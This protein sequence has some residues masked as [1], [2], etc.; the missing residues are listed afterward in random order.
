MSCAALTLTLA[1]TNELQKLLAEGQV[2]IGQ[3]DK[4]F[5]AEKAE[6]TGTNGIME[7]TGNPAWRAGPRGGKGDVL[8]VKPA[9]E[10]MLA[11][12]NAVMRLPAAELGQSAFT[13]LSKPKRSEPR[14]TT[15]EF[16]EVYCQEYLLTSESA[17]F[18]GGVRIEHPQMT[19]TCGEMTLLTPPELG[20]AGHLMIAEPAVLFDVTDDTGRTFHGK[21]EKAVYT[22]RITPL[23]TNDFVVLTGS[24]ATL[25]VTN[26]IGRNNLITLDLAS[27]TLTAPGQYKLWGSAPPSTAPSLVPAK[28]KRKKSTRASS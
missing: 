22:H 16:A 25:E 4:Q 9:R 21:G 18:R 7:L 12:G 15:N 1:G 5:T 26:L 23:L 17:L 10:E 11:Q 6:Y 3:E 27:H 14:G 2:V 19:W 20:K 28:S 13:A 24:P 8:R